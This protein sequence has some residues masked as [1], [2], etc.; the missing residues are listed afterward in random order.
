MNLLEQERHVEV[1]LMLGTVLA[2]LTA[3]VCLSVFVG[4]GLKP[5]P[6]V[7][8]KNASG[9]CC[10]MSDNFDEEVDM[11]DKLR[12]VM[13]KLVD[14]TTIGKKMGVGRDGE[15]QKH[16]SFKVKQVLRI[17]N[18]KQWSLYAHARKV[19]PPFIDKVKDMPE[20]K[21]AYTIDAVQ[22]IQDQVFAHRELD[23]VYGPF[24]KGL[25]CDTSRNEV[26][27]F[28]GAPMINAR[29]KKGAVMFPPDGGSPM[30]A[31]KQT[32]FDERLGN[33]TGML[34]SGTYF[35]DYACKADQYAGRYHEH[36]DGIDPGSVGEEGAMFLSRVTLGTP[37]VTTQSLEQLRRPPCCQGHFDFQ[38]GCKALNFGKPWLEKGFAF[39]VCDHARFDSVIS[40]WTVDGNPKNFQEYVLYEKKAYPEFLI[41]Y[42]RLAAEI[43][44]PAAPVA[45]SIPTTG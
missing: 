20:D 4:M 15:W 37:Y 43:D 9:M 10:V 21:R 32:G 14:D 2:V 30:D 13:Q 25:K 17:E 36:K 6:P 23:P 8:W 26:M 34:G 22:K 45:P 7:Y 39:E 3:I 24:L 31:I 1:A 40:D 29:N 33:V 42:E 16:K 18:G 38:L 28:H 27:L 41:T 44:E 5:A 35:A 11:T 12:D 19:T